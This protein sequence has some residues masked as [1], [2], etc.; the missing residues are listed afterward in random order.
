MNKILLLCFSEHIF[1]I[2]HFATVDVCSVMRYVKKLWFLQLKPVVSSSYAGRC[3]M[4]M[5]H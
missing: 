3:F 2:L 1:V 5:L 4:A